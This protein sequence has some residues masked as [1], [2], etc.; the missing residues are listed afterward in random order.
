MRDLMGALTTLVLADPTI[1]GLIADRVLVN[2]IPEDVIA[3]APVRRPPSI[4]VLRMAGGGAK[5]DLLPVVDTTVTAL[6]YGRNDNKADELLRAVAQRFT[7]LSREIHADVLIHHINPT[8]GPIPSVEPDLVWPAVAQVF[9][10]K[11]GLLE[12][13]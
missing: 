13:A 5:A 8:G 9:T 3:A 6:C 7:L 4:L 11:A 12:V 2:E 10:I 1:A